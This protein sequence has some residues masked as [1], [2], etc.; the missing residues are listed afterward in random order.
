MEPTI[1]SKPAVIDK[2]E[3]LDFAESGSCGLRHLGDNI[4]VEAAAAAVVLHSDEVGDLRRETVNGVGDENI[5]RLERL[6][7]DVLHVVRSLEL[8]VQLLGTSQCINEH[9]CCL[10]VCTSSLEPEDAELLDVF[11][12][13]WL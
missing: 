5:G 9:E 2:V 3:S 11:L 1:Y 4:G 10:C 8:S 6:A 12:E 13:N 7:R